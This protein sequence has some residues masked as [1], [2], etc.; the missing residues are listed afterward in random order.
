VEFSIVAPPM[1]SPCS[2]APGGGGLPS[3]KL[4]LL[5]AGTRLVMPENP[6]AI[7]EDLAPASGLALLLLPAA[8]RRSGGASRQG[9][10]AEQAVMRSGSVLIASLTPD[11]APHQRAP[12]VEMSFT[13][14]FRWL[15]RLATGRLRGVSPHR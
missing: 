3:R 9:E 4:N 14:L 1:H 2:P 5:G 8:A 10:R 15:A 12:Q 13:S 11:L 6:V 7:N